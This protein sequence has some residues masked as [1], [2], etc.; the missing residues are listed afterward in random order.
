MAGSGT[1]KARAE[2]GDLG[3]LG[4]ISIT[5]VPE[6]VTY[7]FP[8]VV[9]DDEVA[10]AAAAVAWGSDTLFATAS[11]TAK[12]ASGTNQ[13]VDEDTQAFGEKKTF[14]GKTGAK[15]NA[16]IQASAKTISQGPDADAESVGRINALVW[17]I[18]DLPT[19]VN[20]N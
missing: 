4:S 15:E 7:N 16:W 3:D 2:D 10:Y 9:D 8:N 18:I 14:Q 11:T 13:E 12:A 6:V 19:Y 17:E 1:A 5:I 20:S